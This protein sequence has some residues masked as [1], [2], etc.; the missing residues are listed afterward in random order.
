[1]L[2]KNVKILLKTIGLLPVTRRLVEFLS[3]Y[4][5]HVVYQRQFRKFKRAHAH[6]LRQR[7]SNPNPRQKVALVASP[8]FPEVV[9]ELGLIKGLELA[10]F[11]PVVL[12][13]R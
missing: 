11:V 6:V 8:F 3:G 10:N 7:L 9:I 13:P 1:M 2:R 4:P 5:R 12:V